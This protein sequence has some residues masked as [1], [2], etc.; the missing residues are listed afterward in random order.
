MKY[1]W[2]L[3]DWP[4]FSFNLE[5]IQSNLYKFA[6]EVGL[7]SGLLKA[8]NQDS[9]DEILVQTILVEALKTSEIENEYLSRQ[10]CD[11]FYKKQFTP[12]R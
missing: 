7:V 12:K 8:T 4:N 2:E 3:P 5:T 9:H 10:G 1:N 11:V 6:E